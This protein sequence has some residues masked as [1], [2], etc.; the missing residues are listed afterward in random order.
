M[1]PKRKPKPKH[2]PKKNSH[3]VEL[4][5]P[6]Y[7]LVKG[8]H[9][10]TLKTEDELRRDG[11]LDDTLLSVEEAKIESEPI[12]IPPTPQRR[13]DA[14]TEFDE[15][16][17]IAQGIVLS[18]PIRSPPN[19]RKKRSTPNRNSPKHVS[20]KKRSPKRKAKVSASQMKSALDKLS[21][22]AKKEETDPAKVASL[23]HESMCI[24]YGLKK[25]PLIAQLKRTLKQQSDI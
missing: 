24:I 1:G 6:M 10:A 23:I 3:N 21:A 15:A 17:G 12:P 13:G 4:I 16:I 20:Q 18:P 7:K 2:P 25:K 9:Q 22:A 8:N 19:K 14:N 5:N 11:L